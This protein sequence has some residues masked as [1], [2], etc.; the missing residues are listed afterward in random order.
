MKEVKPFKLFKKP[1][2]RGRTAERVGACVFTK[3][4]SRYP[5]VGPECGVG[6]GGHA[7]NVE[8]STVQLL[9]AFIVAGACAQCKHANG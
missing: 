8:I 5:Y 7:E 6:D 9:P 3:K 2:G 4:R 1:H